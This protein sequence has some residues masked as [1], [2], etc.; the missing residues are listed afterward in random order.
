[1]RSSCAG[2]GG[3]RFRTGEGKDE[4]GEAGR[5]LDPSCSKFVLPYHVM[6]VEE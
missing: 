2:E 4:E 1:M 3:L 6:E 5:L